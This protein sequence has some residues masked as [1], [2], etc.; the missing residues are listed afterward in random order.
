MQWRYGSSH[1]RLGGIRMKKILVYLLTAMLAFQ[2]FGITATAA[3]DANKAEESKE[4]G[5]GIN[6]KSAIL[7]E[8]ETGNILYEFNSDVQNRPASVTKIMTLL[9]AYDA[10][11]RGDVNE[12][13]IVTISQY[14]AGI[15]GST[16]FIDTDEQIELGL[17]M[18]GVAVASGND[19]ATAIAEYIGGSEEGF[20][21][22]MNERAKELGMKNTNFVNPCGLDAEGHLTTARDIAIMSR[23]LIT[24]YPKVLELTSIF[25]DTLPHKRKDGEELTDLTN[26][27]KLVKFY[28]GCNGLKTG[29]TSKAL[30]SLSCT[31]TRNNLTLISVVMGSENKKIRTKDIVGMLNYG[32]GN[33]Q[34]LVEADGDKLVGELKVKQG[35]KNKVDCY[36]EKDF[37]TLTKKSAQTEIKKEYV[38][39]ESI[40]APLKA[41]QKVGEVV[42]FLADKEIGR[43][44]IIVKEDIEKATFKG[45]LRHLIEIWF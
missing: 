44:S 34:M 35:L 3:D 15:E 10:I 24:K 6:S 19:A 18:K 39:N 2:A 20:V 28:D 22:M 1:V 7:M 42:Y 8:A 30:Y 12:K 38:I 31:A 21:N 5:L 4:Q 29:F 43:G 14:A 25:H 11:A 26:T 32:F 41:G 17:L 37:K 27:N 16:I 9:L 45:M 36:I 13:D 33:Y 23:E 40:S